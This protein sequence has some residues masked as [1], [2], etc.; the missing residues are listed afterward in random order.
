[1]KANICLT[2]ADKQQ[3]QKGRLLCAAFQ[4]QISAMK[5]AATMQANP[6]ATKKTTSASE[7]EASDQN[8]VD[9][10]H[11]ENGASQERT[12]ERDSEE[13]N[14]IVEVPPT[15]QMASQRQVSVAGKYCDNH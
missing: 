9:E 3:G 15:S 2:D 5:E 12:Q 8:K 14:D 4:Q 11:Q 13:N 1:M 7:P 6:T 10:E